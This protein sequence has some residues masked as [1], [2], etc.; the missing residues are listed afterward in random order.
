MLK[1]LQVVIEAE[2]LSPTKTK[3]KSRHFEMVI[4]EPEALGGKDEAPNP[5]EYLAAALAGC[6]NVTG[7]IVAKEMGINVENLKMAI[8]GE[9][10]LDGFMG[11]EGVR[12][13]YKWMKVELQFESSA[14]REKIEEWLKEVERRCPVS[15]NIKNPTPVTIELKF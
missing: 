12:P 14:P 5:V 13:G 11:K 3:I 1:N 6:L 8:S 2:S 7:N 15:D 4:D 10:D 9:I